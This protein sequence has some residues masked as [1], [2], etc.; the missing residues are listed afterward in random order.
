MAATS[1]HLV[2]GCGLLALSILFLGLVMFVVVMVSD[3][4]DAQLMKFE[5]E[6]VEGWNYWRWFYLKR[7]L[8][9]ITITAI[10]LVALGC[11]VAWG[12]VRLGKAVL[13]NKEP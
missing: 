10:V 13:G 2:Q 3:G 4:L 5:A 1:K 9:G 11:L 7:S 12:W 6:P 8:G